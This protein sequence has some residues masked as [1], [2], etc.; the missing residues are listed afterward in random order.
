MSY[1]VKLAW[2]ALLPH[3]SIW[4]FYFG[5]LAPKQ[6]RGELTEPG[7]LGLFIAC[8]IA[9]IVVQVALSILATVTSSASERAACDEREQN[10]AL[11]AGNFGF[12]VMTAV[13]AGLA[14][15][16][17]FYSRN[18]PELLDGQPLSTVLLLAINAALLALVLGEIVRQ[19][20]QITLLYRN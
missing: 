14:G 8:L 20:T 10:A 3:A 17:Y 1:R 11:K 7:V 2:A 12:G 18:H 15:F 16:G 4:G 9:V 19:A 13:L 5:K 6:V